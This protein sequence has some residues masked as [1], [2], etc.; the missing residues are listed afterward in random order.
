[1]VTRK[2]PLRVFAEAEGLALAI[3]RVTQTLPRTELYGLTTQ[4]RRAANSIG[5]NLAEGSA[6]PS[7]IEFARFVG[8]AGGSAAELRFQLRI[9]R[10]LAPSEAQQFEELLSKVDAL[11]RQMR[12]LRKRLR[13]QIQRTSAKSQKPTARSK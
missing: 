12:S 8:I 1:M 5:S 6:R 13:E 3:Y 10:K 7:D 9:C 4:M 11:R 2:T